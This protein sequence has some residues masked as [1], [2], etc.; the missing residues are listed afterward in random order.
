MPVALTL[1][2]RETRISM[3]A[4]DRSTWSI[5]SDDVVWQARF[6]AIGA[7]LVSQVGEWKEYTLPANQISLRNPSKLTDA[8]REERAERARQQFSRR[9]LPAQNDL[10]GDSGTPVA[11]DSLE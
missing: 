4:D 7:T 6:E 3:M 5:G 2:E 11:S 10:D 9:S 8:Q 1:A